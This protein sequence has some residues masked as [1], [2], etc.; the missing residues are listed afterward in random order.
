MQNQVSI[1]D[2]VSSSLI[3]ERLKPAHKKQQLNIL[4][5]IVI[6]K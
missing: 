6:T 2:S 4:D 1:D 3:I 5:S